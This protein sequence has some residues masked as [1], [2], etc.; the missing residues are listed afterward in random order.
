MECGSNIISG[1]KV[2]EIMAHVKL[3]VS[4]GLG[5]QPPIEYLENNV[6]DK[7]ARI[8]SSVLPPYIQSNRS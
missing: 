2:D 4:L 1:N 5:W 8:I 3:V 6:S 7:V